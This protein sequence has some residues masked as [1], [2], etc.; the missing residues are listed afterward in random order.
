MR[1]VRTLVRQAGL[2]LCIALGGCASMK[3]TPQ[4]DYV[5]SCVEAC[6]LAIPP[7][8]QVENVDATGR[9]FV[10]C[11]GTLANMDSFQRCMQTQFN[12]RPYAVWLNERAK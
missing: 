6:K 3:N 8:C 1:T 12:E 2:G 5:W 7:Q 9:Y 10:N 11:M 4:Q